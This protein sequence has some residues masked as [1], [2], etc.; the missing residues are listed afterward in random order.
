MSIVAFLSSRRAL[1]AGSAASIA[2]AV[3]ARTPVGAVA[4]TDRALLDML[5]VLEQIQVVHFAAMLDEYDEAAFAAAGYPEGTR[6]GIEQIL[7]ADSTHLA[8]LARP[9]GAPLPPPIAPSFISLEQALRDAIV[10]KDLSGPAYGGVIETIGRPGIVPD[11]I[12]SHAVEARHVAWLSTLLGD[13]P[14]PNTIDPSLAPTDVL[15]R[16]GEMAQAGSAA[17]TPVEASEIT[18][19]LIEAIAQNLGTDIA[20]LEVVRI[21]PRD[22][23]DA[24]LG[25]PQPG[26]AYAQVIT[27]GFLIVVEAAGEQV[28]YHADEQGNVT[29][30]P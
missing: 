28:E 11:L 1:L 25:C 15:A 20:E 7:A 17:A 12:G 18:A 9:E 8:R 6:D 2:A 14:F 26:H 13:N 4:Q 29:R 24:S 16:L 19:P 27:P 5:F 22:W 30:C 23:P 10:L 21:E 3:F